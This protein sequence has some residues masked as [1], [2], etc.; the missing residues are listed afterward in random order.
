MKNNRY[1]KNILILFTFIF[2]L[3]GI[4]HYSNNVQAVSAKL[5]KKSVTMWVGDTLQ[6]KVSN[7]KDKVKWSSNKKSVATVSTKGKVKAKKS[8]KAVI[9]AKVGNKKLKCNIT[10][11]KT[12]LS[13]K[14]ITITYGKNTPLKLNY[15]KKKVA[16]SSSDTRIAYADGKNVYAKSVGDAVITAKCNGKSYT[17]KITVVSG[18]TEAFTENGI[19]T[20]KGKVALYIHTYNK[21][22]GN[23]ITKDEAKALGWEGGSLLSYAPYKCIGGDR[24]SN[25]EGTLPQ[26]SGR[27]YYECDIDTLGALQRGAKRLVYSN[28]GLI[29]YTEDH[30][31]TFEALY[32]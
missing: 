28:D 14:T 32:K 17:C 3:A 27:V 13:A 30:Y 23:F 1:I 20:S 16:W 8:G 22:P 7:T 24:Y 12:E 9:T 2:V 5:N 19:Y 31:A 18:E 15:P 26:K 25:Y 29:Y 6:L 21:L 11:R 4:L 10:V